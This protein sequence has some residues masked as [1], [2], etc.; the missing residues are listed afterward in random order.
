MATGD[1]TT[2]ASSLSPSPLLIVVVPSSHL[3]IAIPI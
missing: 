3:A 1:T 2:V